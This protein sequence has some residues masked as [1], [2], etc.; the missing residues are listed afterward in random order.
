M[1]A[2]WAAAVG[3]VGVPVAGAVLD[4]SRG[5]MYL[6]V[7]LPFAA[8]VVFFAVVLHGEST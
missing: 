6:L 2:L 4:P 3:L 8:A 1:R 7:A 5:G